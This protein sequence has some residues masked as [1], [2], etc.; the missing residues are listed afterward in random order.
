MCPS[1]RVTREEEH[2]TRGRAHLLWEMTQ[3]DVIHDGGRMN[4][5]RNRWISASPAK[6]AK[7]TAR[8]GSTSRLIR[9]NFSRTTTRANA[10]P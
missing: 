3:G 10:A 2:S 9:R 1:F 6:D 5:S 8:W 7:A 4:K